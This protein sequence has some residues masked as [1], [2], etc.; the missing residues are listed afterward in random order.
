MD[1][2]PRHETS[3]DGQLFWSGARRW[4]SGYK[5]FIDPDDELH[6]ELVGAMARI[7]AVC[8]GVCGDPEA[9]EGGKPTGKLLH[10]L[11]SDHPWRSKVGLCLCVCASACVCRTKAHSMVWQQTV[12]AALMKKPT[13]E[14]PAVS[15]AREEKNAKLKPSAWL[16]KIRKLVGKF[17]AD[18]R[19][20]PQHFEKDHDW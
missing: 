9:R 18:D 13:P 19:L 17:E 4:P 11:P 6:V 7:L 8:F 20:H 15:I 1:E 5:Q 16:K 10:T 12:V 2:H 14:A 3:K